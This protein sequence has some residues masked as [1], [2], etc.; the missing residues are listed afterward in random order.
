[1]PQRR[2]ECYSPPLLQIL[3]VVLAHKLQQGL[4]QCPEGGVVVDDQHGPGHRLMVERTG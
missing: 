2:P 3:V 4:G 1:M